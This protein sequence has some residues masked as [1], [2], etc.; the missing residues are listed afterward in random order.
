[1][2]EY[3]SAR[4]KSGVDVGCNTDETPGQDAQPDTKGHT[5]WDS[6]PVKCPEQGKLLKQTADESFC[7]GLGRGDGSDPGQ[8]VRDFFS[9]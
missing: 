2:L 4:K 8:T 7:S 1:M 3:Y 9:R 5:P 6:I